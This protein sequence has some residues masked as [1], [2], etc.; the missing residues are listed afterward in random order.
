MDI[1]LN[2]ASC[3]FNNLIFAG[4]SQSSYSNSTDS[5]SIVATE[6]DMTP[7]SLSIGKLENRDAMYR[8]CPSQIQFFSIFIPEN[9]FRQTFFK[10]SVDYWQTHF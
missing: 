3:S 2:A 8:W 5:Q 6:G 4:V 10:Y 9:L 7:G 1:L